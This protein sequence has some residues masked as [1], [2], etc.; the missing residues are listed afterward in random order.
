MLKNTLAGICFSCITQLSFAGWQSGG[1]GFVGDSQNPW[2][3]DNTE[4]VSYCVLMG[5]ESHFGASLQQAESAVANAI[6]YWKKYFKENETMVWDDIF[7]HR[8][9]QIRKYIGTQKF[10]RVSCNK[11]PD[12][13][14]QMG[15]LKGN[16]QK[17][18]ISNPNAIIGMAV[19]TSY[20]PASLK[21]K[22]FIYISPEKGPLALEWANT[23][24][25]STFQMAEKRWTRD[26]GRILELVLTHELGHVFGF[27]H[28]DSEIMAKDAPKKMISAG[29]RTRVSV[30]M[31]WVGPKKFFVHNRF[32]N[33]V[34]CNRVR[35]SHLRHLMSEEFAHKSNKIDFKYVASS[36]QYDVFI[37]GY[38]SSSSIKIGTAKQLGETVSDLK[39]LYSIDLYVTNQY[40]P[41]LGHGTAIPGVHFATPISARLNFTPINGDQVV[42]LKLEYN[43]RGIRV[44]TIKDGIF[45]DFFLNDCGFSAVP[46]K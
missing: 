11:D 31:H 42:P 32:E 22:G 23:S 10:N 25:G 24:L 20:D 37:R 38:S 41:R 35:K 16:D 9:H 14:F 45:D 4:V 15:V 13:V 26:D 39:S 33:G 6:R 3:V 28:F 21:G 44:N 34:T 12:I 17:S 2:F 7:P 36:D 40:E 1:G 43:G 19:R 18:Y 30:G 46:A 27:K 5:N 29:F 8:P